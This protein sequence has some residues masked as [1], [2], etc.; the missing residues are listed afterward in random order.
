MMD[1]RNLLGLAVIAAFALPLSGS[2]VAQQRSLKEQ[3]VGTWTITQCDWANPDGTKRPLVVGNNPVG[4]FIFTNNGRFSF[5]VTADIP[6]WASIDYR[7]T[8][9]EENKAVVEG[10][11]SYFGTYTAVDNTIALH[12]ERS[13]IPNLNG[14]DGRRI[15]NA[16]S[17][18][19][20][21]WTNPAVFGLGS[22]TCSN[23]RIQ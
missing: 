23:K 20:M 18:D 5:Q 12:I 9:P 3:I 8:T 16:V 11:M 4:Q 21:N 1:Q 15:V 13:S 10:T 14:T 17:D 6:K 22:I 2:A 19:E 7:K